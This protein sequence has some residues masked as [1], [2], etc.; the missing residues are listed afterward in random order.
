MRKRRRKRPGEGVRPQVGPQ[1]PFGR[2]GISQ[3]QR[4]ARRQ[5]EA[6]PGESHQE[7]EEP[8]DEHTE[9]PGPGNGRTRENEQGQGPH[10]L[11]LAVGHE[12]RGPP[13]P[14]RFRRRWSRTP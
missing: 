2:Y 6:E 13:G 14:E 8:E 1:I 12:H 3:P 10:T 4:P 11:P 9:E 5:E 7:A